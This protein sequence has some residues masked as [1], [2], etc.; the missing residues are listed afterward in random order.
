MNQLELELQPAT[1]SYRLIP[2]SQGQFA[3]VSPED[4]D[5]LMKFKWHAQWDSRGQNFRAHRI[6][7]KPKQHGVYMHRQIMGVTVREIEVDHW[8]HDALDNQ[9]GN[10]RLAT[11][12][13]NNCNQRIRKDNTSGH[14]GVSWNSRHKRWCAQVNIDGKRVLIGRFKSIDDAVSAYEDVARR[15]HGE[16]FCKERV[17]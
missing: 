9:R 8:N 10:L 7:M 12:K 4:Y 13:Q 11:R 14:K 15:V 1:P 6:E 16:F 3:K 17:A 2:L 5:Y